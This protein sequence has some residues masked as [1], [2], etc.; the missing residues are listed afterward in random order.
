MR[1]VIYIGA[2]ALVALTA[3]W[4][5]RVNYAAQAAMNRVQALRS[6]IT[7]QHEALVILRADWA[8]LNAPERLAALLA[9][10]GADLGLVPMAGAQFV[11]LSALPL[12]PLESYWVRADPAV[13]LTAD[14]DRLALQVTP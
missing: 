5:Y 4:A 8:Y 9:A 13:F 7:R 2:A 11:A 10:N 6:E 1:G 3:L 14:D 12:P